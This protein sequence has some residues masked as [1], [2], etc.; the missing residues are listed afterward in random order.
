VRHICALLHPSR[1]IIFYWPGE[2]AS[3]KTFW[4]NVPLRTI[5]V[6]VQPCRN[7][8]RCL[9]KVYFG[10]DE[11]PLTCKKVCATSQDLVLATFH[12]NLDQLRW[13]SPGSNEFVQC[14]CRYSDDFPASQ[15]RT[16]SVGFN[17]A[18]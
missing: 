1:T 18:L 11:R 2:Q 3:R 12:V 16:V 15:D 9:L 8:L 4:G 14:D 17:S 6:F 10:N 7:F 5:P 13:W